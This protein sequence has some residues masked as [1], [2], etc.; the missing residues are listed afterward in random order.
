MGRALILIGLL[1]AAISPL[2]YGVLV[3]LPT[4][5]GCQ[6]GS[7]PTSGCILLGFDISWLVHSLLVSSLGFFFLIPIGFVLM[8][9]GVVIAI[10]NRSKGEQNA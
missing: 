4:M 3:S 5:P 7:A 10:V 1:V 2:A 6:A 9:L 8:V